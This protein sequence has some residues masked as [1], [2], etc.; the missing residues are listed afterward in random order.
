MKHLAVGP[1]DVHCMCSSLGAVNVQLT[2]LHPWV[3]M[4]ADCQAT[5]RYSL[6]F[7]VLHWVCPIIY[8]KIVNKITA[9]E[10]STGNNIWQQHMKFKIEVN[11]K[12][13]FLQWCH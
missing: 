10:I 6:F 7:N 8:S 5:E 1:N 9:A 11:N 12:N 2:Q 13:N 4:T 3:I